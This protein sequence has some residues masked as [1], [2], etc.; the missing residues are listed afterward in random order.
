MRFFPSKLTNLLST[1]I[2]WISHVTSGG[3][4]ASRHKGA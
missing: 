1:S 3:D 2:N 4:N